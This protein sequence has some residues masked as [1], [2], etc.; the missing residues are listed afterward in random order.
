LRA[1]TAPANELPVGLPAPALVSARA[2]RGARGHFAPGARSAQSRGGSATKGKAR[3][4]SSLGLGKLPADAKFLPY[5]RAAA[6]F[7]R[8]QCNELARTVGGGR[9]GPGPSS[10]VG[11]AALALAWSRHFSDEAARSGDNALAVTAARL[12][13]QSRQSLLTAHELCA[14]EAV[15]RG[16]SESTLARMRREMDAIGDE[17][18]DTRK[19][20][21]S[22]AKSDVVSTASTDALAPAQPDPDA[23]R[24]EVLGGVP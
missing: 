19:A 18:A 3:L 14:R 13:D 1:E 24:Q 17:P 23:L 16:P 22:R 8:A 15:A 9:C 12:A 6:A 5:R 10:I 11:S 21:P 20:E 7:R 2:E 4:T